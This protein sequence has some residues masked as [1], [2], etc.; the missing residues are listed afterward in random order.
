[1]SN[2]KVSGVSKEEKHIVPDK[3]GNAQH[4]LMN[5]LRPLTTG[6]AVTAAYQATAAGTVVT[7][8]SRR[9]IVNI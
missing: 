3:K 6:Y 2:N 9:D 7:S 4:T 8:S 1:M 5:M